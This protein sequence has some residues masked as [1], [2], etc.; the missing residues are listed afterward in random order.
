MEFFK[1]STIFGNKAR[2]LR[3]KESFWQVQKKKKKHQKGGKGGWVK[4]ENGRRE[5]GK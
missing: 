1:N 5:G 4:G 2:R 3:R